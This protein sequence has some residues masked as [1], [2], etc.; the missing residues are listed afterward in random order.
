MKFTDNQRN[1]I[2]DHSGNLLVSAA[3]GSGKTAV[4]VKRIEQEIL[5]KDDPYDIDRVLVMTFTEA[6][7][8]EM[9]SRILAAINEIIQKGNASPRLYRQAALVNNAHISTIHGFCLSVIRN[10]FHVVDLSPDVKVMDDAESTLLKSDTLNEILEECY[11]EG[12][13][14]FLSMSENIA[15]DRN[16]SNLSDVIMKLY[17]FAVSVPD[18]KE[19][20]DKCINAYTNVTADNFEK[21]PMVLFYFKELKNSVNE[22][23]SLSEKAL[24]ICNEP[25]GPYPYASAIENDIEKLTQIVKSNDLNIFSQMVKGY[26]AKGFASIRGATK[27]EVDEELKKRVSDIRDLVKKRIKNI[28]SELSDSID[29]HVELVNA[30][31]KDVIELID[32]TGRFYDR[33]LE[34][35]KE[36]NL[37]D[38][39]DME[40]YCLKILTESE[41]IA[42]EYRDYFREIYVDEY[43]DSNMVQDAIVNAIAKNNVFLVGDVK[44]SIYR[45][46]MARPEL[47]M[48][49]FDRYGKGER[50]KRIDLSDN[51]RSRREVV[52]SVNEVFTELMHKEFGGIEYDADARLNYGAEYYDE[53]ENTE[54]NNTNVNQMGQ[55]DRKTKLVVIEK[56]NEIDDKQL[57]ALYVAE[58]INEL[59]DSGMLVYDKNLSRLRPIKYSDIVI[60]LRTSSGWT[61][62]FCSVIEEQGIPIH[63]DSTT[64]Y[65]NAPEILDLMELLK[66]IDNP[67]QDIP[68]ATTM[69]SPLFNFTDEELGYV[70]AAN[71][72]L[73]FYA[74]VTAYSE[75]NDQKGQ[76]ELYSKIKK[77]LETV[78]SYREKAAYTSVYDLLREI[79]DG[80][81][82]RMILSSVNGKKRYM[83]LNMLLSRA[84]A[85]AESSFKGL[86]QFVRYIE[87]LKKNE[88]DYGEANI[89]NENDNS[90]RLLTIH[91]S[92]G[93]EFPVVFLCGMQKGFNLRDA[94]DRVVPDADLGLG[95]YYID[96]EKRTKY[97][98][99]PQRAVSLKNRM[100]TVAEEMRLF[101]VAMTRAREKLIMTAIV[102]KPETELKKSVI[103]SK[104]SS[105]LDFLLYAKGEQENFENIDFEIAPATELVDKLAKKIASND[106]IKEKMF[107]FAKCPMVSTE[108]KKEV[109]EI[110]T[111]LNFSYPYDE[112]D[113]FAKISVTELKKRSM[114]INNDEEN[115]D[116]DS[117]SLF[118]EE[119]AVIPLI[120]A[121]LS[122][123]EKT[124]PGTLYGTAFHRI[125]EL[126]DY[127]IDNSIENIKSFFNKLESEKKIENDLVGIINP[128]EISDFLSSDIGLRMKAAF[129]RNQLKRE[130][131]FVMHDKSGMLVQ[132]IIDAY[133]IEDGQIILVDYKTDAVTHEK[134][135]VDKYHVQLDY[136]ADALERLCKMPV[137]EKIIYSRKLKKSI[138]I[139]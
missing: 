115:T 73:P 97:K 9:K 34:K 16:D 10:H 23:I 57:E 102:K 99:I 82:G 121:F 135:L 17:S 78:N 130:Q 138:I 134:E 28:A 11:E 55:Y 19:W 18:V 58:K 38:F 26:E 122:T 88:V 7:A 36:K 35:K 93:L 49:K 79:V 62:T 77:F 52:D 59:I 13:E 81:Y 100:D 51:F 50:G 31:R 22:L 68:L 128:S 65:F 67:A 111:R 98:T 47:F 76:C 5:R 71:P 132:G 120:P 125:L 110:K 2:E 44:Q 66:T 86:F 56:E 80:E 129:D 15:P 137:G 113:T 3:A 70:R 12:R 4:L 106:I 63:A 101:Y 74:A 14:E 139:S 127:T 60:L 92:K 95:L 112:A 117:S 32:I 90:V 89:N 116:M 8:S 107:D 27:D 85:Y 24:R 43:Q 1:A 103:I 109:E 20:F 41:V 69:K 84:A 136:Y 45:F 42:N 53:A 118:E 133:F 46:R 40:H 6:A 131:P 91:K 29:T 39:N 124:V 105:Y 25:G 83:N 126:W 123:K 30:C 61:E 119:E 72:K 114:R 37:I 104:A 75:E 48:G 21:L 64:G 87:C 108:H 54:L 33:Y 94:S 96:S